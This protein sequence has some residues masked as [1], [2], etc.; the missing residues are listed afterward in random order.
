MDQPFV[1]ASPDLAQKN[2]CGSKYGS[3]TMYVHLSKYVESSDIFSYIYNSF[4]KKL[5]LC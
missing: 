4:G 3:G 2:L 5:I 1:F